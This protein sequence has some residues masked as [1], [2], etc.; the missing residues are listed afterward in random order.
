M[1]PAWTTVVPTTILRLPYSLVEAT[2]WTVLTYFE[3]GLSLNAGRWDCPAKILATS[4]F[5]SVS[6]HPLSILCVNSHGA[7]CWQIAAT[8]QSFSI[9]AKACS[10]KRILER[11][12]SWFQIS[13]CTVT[14]L[15]PFAMFVQVLCIPVHPLPDAQLLCQLLQGHWLH[16]QKYHHRKC[17]G[18]LCDALRPHAWWLRHLFW[19]AFCLPNLQLH[20]CT[21]CIPFVMTE[22][23]SM[24]SAVAASFVH[25]APC[26]CYVHLYSTGLKFSAN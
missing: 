26:A 20:H 22:D 8:Y 11:W 9:L 15:I 10:A 4:K 7:W 21:C 23:S 19:Y 17:R 5:C 24:Q 14:S 18:I 3:V 1:Y 13:S 12:V 2:L 16:L 6:A 25:N